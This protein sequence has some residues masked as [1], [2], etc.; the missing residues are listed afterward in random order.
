MAPV[1]PAA[2]RTVKSGHGAKRGA[3]ILQILVQTCR[4]K[5]LEVTN[6]LRFLSNPQFRLKKGASRYLDMPALTFVH[7]ALSLLGIFAGFVVLFGMFS[8]ERL[9]GWTS[10]FLVTTVL[11]SVTGF[12][13]P[14]HRVLP[15]HVFGV[16]SLIALA[17]AVFARYSRRIAGVW[18]AAYVI[19]AAIA[20]YLNVFIL[21]AQAFQ[22]VPALKAKA[23]TQ[24]EAPFLVTQL[25]VMVILILLSIFAVK[26]FRPDLVRAT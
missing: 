20:L 22:K 9:D 7:V 25:I 17:I 19:T 11:T 23:P 4:V 6:P 3:H 1:S 26:G 21:I 24:S 10:L 15:S 12:F 5:S 13:F 14:F 2:G 18:R 8:A 16:L